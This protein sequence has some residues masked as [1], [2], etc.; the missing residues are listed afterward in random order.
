MTAVELPSGS[1]IVPVG[2][3]I[4]CNPPPMDTDEDFLVLVEDKRD[5]VEYLK[6]LGFEY[7]ADPERVAEYERL[8]ETSQWSFTSLVFGDVN[9]IV[10]DSPFFFERFLTA[11]HICKT[12]NLLNKADRILVFEGVRGHSMAKYVAE[13]WDYIAAEKKRDPSFTAESFDHDGS[14]SIQ[15]V[16]VVNAFAKAVSDSQSAF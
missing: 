1:I 7:S 12:L 13:G 16:M 15:R 5:A 4:T 6:W 11:T 2:S 8:N 9:Y 14:A 3:R 10:T